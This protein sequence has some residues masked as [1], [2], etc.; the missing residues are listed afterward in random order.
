MALSPQAVRDINLGRGGTYSLSRDVIKHQIWDSKFYT[1]G[2]QA[3]DHDY[4]T[5]PVGASWRA[6]HTKSLGE[7]NMYDSGKLPNGQTFLIKRMSVALVSP[8]YPH[9]DVASQNTPYQIADSFAQV[10]INSVFEIRIAGREF[11]FQVH[12]S[13]FLPAVPKYSQAVNPAQF[14]FGMT[15]ASGWMS[16]GGMPIFLDQLVNF[17]VHQ[18]FTAPTAGGKAGLAS[19]I[20]NLAE[21]YCRL[22]IVLEGVLTRAK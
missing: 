7:T 16:L 8:I 1:V 3:V 22:N 20:Q 14:H 15:V 12:G 13:Q 6:V 11:D 4:F 10:L 18:R 17:S 5:Q 9:G 2:E 19:S 21:A